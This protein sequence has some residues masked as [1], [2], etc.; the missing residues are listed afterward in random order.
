MRSSRSRAHDHAPTD[1]DPAEVVVRTAADLEQE[2]ERLRVE[3]DEERRR[4][5]RLL[6]DF[7]NFRR[8]VARE[9][10]AAEGAG[11][12]AALL[13]MLDV[14]DS[15]ERALES[16]GE[17]AALA[18]GVAATHR[19]FLAALARAGARRIETVGRAFDPTMH[20]VVSALPSATF[21]PGIVT[22]EVRSG[23]RLSDELIRPAQVIV[24]A[25]AEPDRDEERDTPWR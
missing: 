15:L 16:G 20:E 18:E 25:A 23:W 12:R 14:L 4:G 11:R 8:R 2:A 1:V 22:H 10:G 24:A 9:Q 3:L 5:V 21:D 19:Q 17:D 6:A 13:P 7:D